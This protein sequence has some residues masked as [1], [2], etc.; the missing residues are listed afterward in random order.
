MREVNEGTSRGKIL[1]HT[2]ALSTSRVGE[3]NPVLIPRDL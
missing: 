1:A 2:E 3:G